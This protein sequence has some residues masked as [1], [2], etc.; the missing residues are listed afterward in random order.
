MVM[1][2]KSLKI[3]C[4]YALTGVKAAVKLLLVFRDILSVAV[5]CKHS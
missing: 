4:F 1:I 5:L 3:I 2:V